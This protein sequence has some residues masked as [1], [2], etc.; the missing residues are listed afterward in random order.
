MAGASATC[1][2]LSSFRDAKMVSVLVVIGHRYQQNFLLDIT[3]FSSSAWLGQNTLPLMKHAYANKRRTAN[4]PYPSSPQYPPASKGSQLLSCETLSE[5]P[6]PHH[7]DAHQ[8]TG[9]LGEGQSRGW[10]M[11]RTGNQGRSQ[12]KHEKSGGTTEM[13]ASVGRMRWANSY[14]RYGV[15]NR[16]DL[17]G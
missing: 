10:H 9:K 7:Q 16:T 14:V 3:A 13:R 12:R 8:K 15:T 2:G 17:C 11:K 4:M 6:C 5:Q 1:L